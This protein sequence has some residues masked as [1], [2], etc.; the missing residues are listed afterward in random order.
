[1]DSDKTSNTG[2]PSAAIEYIDAVI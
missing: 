2:L 1:M